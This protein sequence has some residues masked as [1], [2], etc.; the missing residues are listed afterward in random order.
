MTNNIDKAVRES[1]EAE[2]EARLM[3]EAWEVAR[4][5]ERVAWD[6]ASEARLKLA[7]AQDAERLA[8]EAAS[9]ARLE[10]ESAQAAA[11]AA[12]LRVQRSRARRATT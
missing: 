6:V 3:Q 1:A 5:A 10:L 7:A 12:R 4:D 8:Q 9:A 2:R 11:S